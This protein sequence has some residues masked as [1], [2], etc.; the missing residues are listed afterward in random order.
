[1]NGPAPLRVG[2]PAPYRFEA[3]SGWASRLALAQGCSL[4]EL[5]R[6]LGLRRDA[7]F[8]LDLAMHGVALDELR[9][10]C[11]LPPEAFAATGA[12]MTVLSRVDVRD[13][14][15]VP[16][17]RYCPTCLGE[18]FPTYFDVRWRFIAWEYCPAHN[19]RMEDRC[20]KCQQLVLYPTDMAE[21]FAGAGGNAS[22]R[23]CQACAA[24]LGAAP[25][26]ERA[27]T[28]G[29]KDR[30][31]D[32]VKMLAALFAACMGADGAEAIPGVCELADPMQRPSIGKSHSFSITWSNEHGCYAGICEEISSFNCLGDSREAAVAG[33]VRLAGACTAASLSGWTFVVGREPAD[34]AA[35]PYMPA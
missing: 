4:S 34:M 17:F 24:D 13:Q 21:S 31:V 20:W 22:Q 30:V 11:G 27:S 10:R 18:G 16:I 33:V 5:R 15:V 9:R 28:S 6:F 26:R 1:M 14:L 8:D 19:C 29:D 2:V 25:P 23:R 32:G 7:N 35:L 12:I 3:P